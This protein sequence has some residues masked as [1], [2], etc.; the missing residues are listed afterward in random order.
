M[1]HEIDICDSTSY[2]I[3]V[4]NE[5]NNWSCVIMTNFVIKFNF[6]KLYKCINVK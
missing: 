4:I 1:Y 2:L 5:G 3:K 6:Y